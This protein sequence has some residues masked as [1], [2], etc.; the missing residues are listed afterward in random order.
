MR[1][2][3]LNAKAYR[4]YLWFMFSL[5]FFDIISLPIVNYPGTF[6]ASSLDRTVKEENDC[7][8]VPR[9]ETHENDE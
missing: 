9:S 7:L 2:N 6:M 3:N 1:V 5:D 8:L 4:I